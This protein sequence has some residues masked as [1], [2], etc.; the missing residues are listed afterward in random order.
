MLQTAPQ[1]R[2]CPTPHWKDW[3][4]KVRPALEVLCVQLCVL[5]KGPTAPSLS[6]P[7][8]KGWGMGMCSPKNGHTQKGGQV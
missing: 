2:A 8:W 1:G 6:F 4:S 7:F 3:P 5:G